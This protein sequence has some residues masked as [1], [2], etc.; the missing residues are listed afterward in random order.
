LYS[1]AVLAAAP[2]ALPAQAL[3]RKEI[4][5][6]LR[7]DKHPEPVFTRVNPESLSKSIEIAAGRSYAVFGY[8]TPSV[9][10]RLPAVDNSAYA[11]VEFPEAKPLGKDEKVLPHEIEKGLYDSDTHTTQVR[12]VAPGR[13][14]LVP[15]ARARGRVKVRYPVAVH[16]T[17]VRNS[18]QAADLGIAIDGPYVTYSEKALGLPEAAPFTG[19]E[20]LRAY[21]A[22]GKRLERYEGFQKTEFKNEVS[23][24][25]VA[26]WGPVASVR[27]DTADSWSDI[28]LPFDLPAAPMRPAGKEGVGP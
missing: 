24:R 8:N 15:L 23:K 12:F 1:A 6:A 5:Q 19:I 27:F 22:S 28:E 13:K 18:P 11:K 17:A 3:S 21:D 14:D 9:I 2:A 7:Y 20:P 26:F 4:E 10:V 25:T 16:T